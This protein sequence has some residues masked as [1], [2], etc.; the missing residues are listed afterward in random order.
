MSLRRVI[1]A[2]MIMVAAVIGSL[3]LGLR[4]GVHLCRDRLRIVNESSFTVQCAMDFAGK[5]ATVTIPPGESSTIPTSV[6]TE[7]GLKYSLSN[8]GG[9]SFKSDVYCC[10]TGG[11]IV[12]VTVNADGSVHEET[13]DWMW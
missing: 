2:T 5:T 8:A 10:P 12:R 6:K 9:L 11:S 13:L 4:G 3:E 7:C 1:A